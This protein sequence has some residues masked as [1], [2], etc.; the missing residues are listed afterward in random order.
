[1]EARHRVPGGMMAKQARA[2]RRVV[3]LLAPGL[4]WISVAYVVPGV[5]IVVYSLLTPKLGGGVVWEATFDSW[6]QIVAKGRRSTAGWGTIGSAAVRGIA[7]TAAA[8]VPAIA[9]ARYLG[10]RIS[11]SL[12]LAGLFGGLVAINHLASAYN[13]Y[14]AVFARSVVWSVLATIICITLALPLA[15][16]ISSRHS[17]V[18]KNALL[19]AVMIPFW[20]SMLVRTYAIR[21]LLANTG[22]VNN[23]LETLGM[24][25]IVFLNT[26]FAVILGLVYTALP[27]MVLPLYAASERVDRAQMEAARDLGARPPQVFADVFV[28]MVKPGLIVGGVMVFVLSVSQYL[29]PT[30]LGGG[31]TNMIANLLELQFGEAFNWPLGAAIAALFSVI[32]LA[33]LYAT[34]GRRDQEQLL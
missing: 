30:L 31:K 10:R 18:T 14:T 17:T 3:P 28:P 19:I 7:A 22:P 13:N 9:A 25:R 21:F 1:M 6:D 11:R 2:R 15:V 12:A 26:R 4:L 5:L 24:D 29:V 23:F 33:G 27:F 16:F 32:T 20:T 8:S 34:V